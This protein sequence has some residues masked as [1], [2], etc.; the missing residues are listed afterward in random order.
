M[1][2][3]KVEF[4]PYIIDGSRQTYLQKK[5]RSLSKTLDKLN[6]QLSEFENLAS[7]VR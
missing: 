5:V 4:D 6:I 7:L 3:E 2:T 1:V